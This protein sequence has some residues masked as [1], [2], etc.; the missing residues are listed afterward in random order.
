MKMKKRLLSAALALCLLLTLL[1]VGAA[2]EEPTPEE[3]TKATV[4]PSVI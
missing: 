3:P 1:P 2:A 4:L